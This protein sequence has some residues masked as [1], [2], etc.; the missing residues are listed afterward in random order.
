MFDKERR[1][2][3]STVGEL[4]SLLSN[5]SDNTPVSICGDVLGWFHAEED[6]SGITLDHS[7][8]DEYYG[9]AV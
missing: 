2:S 7:S 1:D 5:W 3:F 4:R 8:L 9:D 6:N